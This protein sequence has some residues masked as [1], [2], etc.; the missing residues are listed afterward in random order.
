MR[1]D[2]IVVTLLILVVLCAFKNDLINMTG[3]T[4][5]NEPFFDEKS[6]LISTIAN[7]LNISDRRIVNFQYAFVPEGSKNLV[8]RFAILPKNNFE[9][10][11]PSIDELQA[12]I[13]HLFETNTFIINFQDELLTLKSN[14]SVSFD[15]KKES[16]NNS[17]ANKVEPMQDTA[18][19]HCNI[20]PTFDNTNLLKA[21][22]LV[23]SKFRSIP[24]DNSLTRFIEIETKNGKLK[25]INTPLS[26]NN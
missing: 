11:E 26:C 7:K 5:T 9:I 17:K 3:I 19:Y 24:V 21:K 22:S 14:S 1:T 20:N 12:T 13:N 18:E 23:E 2:L 15:T 6:E 8:V 16:F 4:K 10:N 25:S